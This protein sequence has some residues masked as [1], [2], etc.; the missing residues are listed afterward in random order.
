MYDPAKSVSWLF[1]IIFI[2]VFGLI[3]YRIIGR[4]V[5]KEKRFRKLLIN[6]ENQLKSFIS[7]GS[8]YPKR[9]EVT[10][11]IR[12]IKLLESNGSSHLQSGNKIEVLQNGVATFDSLFQGIKQAKESI[13]LDFYIL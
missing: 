12:L 6:H 8:D 7:L 4:N 9:G 3:L 1:V 13:H 5:R 10:K 11:N 2:P